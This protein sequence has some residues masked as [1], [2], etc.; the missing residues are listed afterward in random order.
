MA[1]RNDHT[2][3][4]LKTM[5]IDAGYALMAKRGLHQFSAPPSCQ[6]HRLFGRDAL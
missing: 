3:D 2:R 6:R 4:E 5:A 1:R